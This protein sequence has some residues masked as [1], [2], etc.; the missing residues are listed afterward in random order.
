MKYNFTKLGSRYSKNEKYVSINNSNLNISALA[1]KELGS[2]K[3]VDIYID[4][5]NKAI[6]IV[7]GNDRTVTRAS[8]GSKSFAKILPK[9]KYKMVEDNIFVF[10]Q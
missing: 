1:Y 5:E 6:K 4:V 8:I 9:G 7:E 2:P 10:N 3:S